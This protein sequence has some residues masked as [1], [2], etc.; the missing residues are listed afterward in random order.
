MPSLDMARRRLR[1]PDSHISVPALLVE[2][3]EG[4]VV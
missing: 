1:L 2:E 4:Y 3:G